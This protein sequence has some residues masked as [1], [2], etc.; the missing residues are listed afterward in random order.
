MRRVLLAY[1]AGSLA[2]AASLSG[3]PPSPNEPG[4]TPPARAALSLPAV[5]SLPYVSAG[6]GGSSL[7]VTVTNT[8]AAEATG[9]RWDLLGDP[10]LH[11]GA[12]PDNLPGGASAV[13]EL[14]YDGAP[15]ESIASARLSLSS[16]GETVAAEVYAVAGDPALG[17]GTWESLLGPNGELMGEGITLALPAAPYP[18]EGGTFNDASVRIFL[19]EGYRDLGAHDVVLHFHGHNTT[20]SSTVAS[21][22]YPQHLY[23]SGVNAILVVPQGPV[24]APSGDFGKLMS[25][26]GARAL[27]DQVLIVLYREGKIASPLLGDVLLSSHSGGY[28][29]VAA[30]ISGNDRFPVRQVNLYDSLYGFSAVYA[31]YALAGGVL[32]SNYTATGGTKAN[33]EAL[34]ADLQGAGLDLSET[35]SQRALR[36][37]GAVIY[38]ADTSHGAATRLLGAY[39]EHLRW[40]GLR[41]RHGPRVELREALAGPFGARVRW[42]SPREEGLLGFQ[43]QTSTDGASWEVVAEAGPAQEEASFPLTG[44][45]LFRLVPQIEGLS[46]S[47]ASPVVWLD[48]AGSGLVVNGVD[49]IVDGSFAGLTHDFAA[50]VGR[51]AGT[52]GAISRRALTEDNFDASRAPLLVWLSGDSSSADRSLSAAEQVIV[53]SYL[54]AGGRLLLSGSELAF[55]LASRSPSFLAGTLGATLAADDSASYRL[56]GLG[57]DPFGYSGGDAPYQEDFP[58]A[59]SPQPG[60]EVLLSYDNGLAAAVGNEHR[61]A[62]LGFPLE[63][64]D[65]PEALASLLQALRTYL[66]R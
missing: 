43:L 35:P 28:R 12:T 8:G 5:L 46:A 25:P 15:H 66:E 53:S 10:A 55:D 2:C 42:L 49:R 59:L 37:A 6:A 64:V 23:A 31:E 20:L 56:S 21:H 48:P 3:P 9:L 36:D 51:A 33:N 39:G 29:A 62:L 45:A 32:R 38:F 26:D 13:I 65:D 54:Q 4:E 16:R 57:L 52:S 44:P 14:S 17:Q 18:V 30:N 50:R 40:A 41:S 27:L 22:R 34:A 58:D 63:L 19:P 1:L 7:A 61:A 60:A 11:L 47:L 24:N